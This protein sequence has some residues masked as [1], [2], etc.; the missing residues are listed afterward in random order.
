MTTRHDYNPDAL[1][2]IRNGACAR[3]LGWDEK[4]YGEVC[5]KHGI[6]PM[7]VSVALTEAIPTPP[8]SKD[9]K[10]SL[11]RPSKPSLANSGRQVGFGAPKWLITELTA[12]VEAQRVSRIK[13]VRKAL[14]DAA[15]AEST[16]PDWRQKAGGGAIYSITTT[17]SDGEIDA[18]NGAALL[19]SMTF[20]E[21]AR[22]AVALAVAQAI[23][24]S[25]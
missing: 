19:R 11:A 8:E 4:F 24:V 15:L 5:R 18:I 21:F 17:L 2:R 23:A 22:R 3:D 12:I 1:Q 20:N 10:P 13:F 14:F 9:Y 6:E 25:P 16:L 7:A